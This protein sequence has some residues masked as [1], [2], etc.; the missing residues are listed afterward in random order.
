ML[1]APKLATRD[2]IEA[3]KDEERPPHDPPE[4]P[5]CS[6]KELTVSKSYAQAMTSEY[7]GLWKDSMDRE[8]WGIFNAGIVDA[9]ELQSVEN[10]IHA[11]WVYNWKADEFGWPTKM[12]SRLNRLFYKMRFV[13]EMR[14][15][16]T[17]VLSLYT[18]SGSPQ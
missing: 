10:Y 2:D 7:G 4:L 11:K 17:T 18:F 12:N 13:V 16:P 6:A 1:Y 5:Q 15:V 8:W 9:A 14:F 3:A